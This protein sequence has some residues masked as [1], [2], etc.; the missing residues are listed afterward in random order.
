MNIIGE[1]SNVIGQ[2]IVAT[3][4]DYNI[5]RVLAISRFG[6]EHGY[7]LRFYGDCFRGLDGEYRKKLLKKY[8]EVCDLLE[9]Y[10]IKG[11]DVHTTF[12]L[13]ILI[14]LWDLDSTPYPCGKRIATV[15]PDGTIGPCIRNHSFKTG[16]IF[17]ADPISKITCEEYHHDIGNPNLPDE[18]RVCESRTCCQG[19]CPNEKLVLTGVT[20]CKSIECAIHKE[21]IPR[22]RYLEKLKNGP[23][24]AVNQGPQRSY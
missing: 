17:D 4:D 21:I 11:Y 16:T 6:L 12:L 13:D 8:H 15:F 24:T 7:R 9:Q 20:S 22:L 2:T 19:G 3:L 23:L 5:G 1:R 14:P 18:C 10:V